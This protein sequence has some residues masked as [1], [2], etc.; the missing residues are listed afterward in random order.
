MTTDWDEERRRIAEE[1]LA[2]RDGV[3]LWF[4]DFGERLVSDLS[5][6]ELMV[7][8]FETAAALEAE[9][10]RHAFDLELLAPAQK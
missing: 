6:E 7:A 10:K 1:K 5:K 4:D 2:K 9:R 3:D 8:L